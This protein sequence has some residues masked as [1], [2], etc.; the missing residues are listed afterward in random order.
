MQTVWHVPRRTPGSLFPCRKSWNMA[1]Q[2]RACH[3][4]KYNPQNRFTFIAERMGVSGRSDRRKCG[5]T[6]AG[7]CNLYGTSACFQ[8]PA[9][10]C[11]FST[12]YCSVSIWMIESML[13]ADLLL[14]TFLCSPHSQM[15]RLW[16][17]APF[18]FDR[19]R[20]TIYTSL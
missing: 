2:E 8:W 16:K 11:L 13:K 6:D 9:L 1:G 17:V 14:G 18:L 12:V 19:L 7:L 3:D 15:A 5:F 10:F 4:P 20:D